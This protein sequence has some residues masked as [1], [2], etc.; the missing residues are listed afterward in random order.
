MEYAIKGSIKRFLKENNMRI[1]T[2]TYEALDL[3]FESWLKEAC[4][5]AKKNKRKT[6]TPQDL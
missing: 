6:V 1:A 5:R 3:K 4:E 2:A